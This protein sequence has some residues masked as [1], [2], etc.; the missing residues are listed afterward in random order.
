MAAAAVV[1]VGVKKKTHIL[2]PPLLTIQMSKKRYIFTIDDDCFVAQTPSGERERERG[3]EREIGW[4][5]RFRYTH[6][7]FVA[8]T[9]TK[10][11]KKLNL[12]PF[13]KKK[14]NRSRHQR[15]PPA[16][17]QPL[18][19]FHAPLLQHALRP[20]RPRGRLRARLPLFD[21]LGRRDGDLTR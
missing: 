20:V 11:K 8:A 13:W 7:L 21:A 14:K 17:P 16:H 6:G 19:P 4:K 2:L 1:G 15:P 5:S 18:H 10:K 9:A 3:R 12:D